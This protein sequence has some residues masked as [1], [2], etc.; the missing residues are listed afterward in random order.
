[1][2]HEET[3]DGYELCQ[4]QQVVS[5]NN[6]KSGRLNDERGCFLVRRHFALFSVTIASVLR[7]SLLCRAQYFDDDNVFGDVCR[8]REREMPP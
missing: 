8:R 4:K 3:G 2:D 6:E 7:V 1:M 5:Q